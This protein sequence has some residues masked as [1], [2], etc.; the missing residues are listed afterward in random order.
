METV[1][2]TEAVLLLFQRIAKNY[3]N[4]L[5]RTYVPV[6]FNDL[7]GRLLFREGDASSDKKRSTQLFK[8]L[9]EWLKTFK[10]K[11]LIPEEEDDDAV[12]GR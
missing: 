3:P 5:L 10:S 2:L 12:D 9:E 4:V 7:A 8:V 6:N 1:S 11:S